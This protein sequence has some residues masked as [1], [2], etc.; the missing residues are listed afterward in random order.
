VAVPSPA[1]FAFSAVVALVLALRSDG[2][3]RRAVFAVA[4]L[5]FLATFC[6]GDPHKL[7]PFAALLLLGYVSLWFVSERRRS[8][9][10]VACVAALLA[11]FFVV[12]R[13][14]FVPSALLLPEGYV[15]VGVSYVFFRLVHLVVDRAQ[16]ALEERVGPVA[17]V[18]YAL[19]FTALVSGPIQLYQ[20]YR[21]TEFVAPA[22]L[23]VTVAGSAFARIVLGCFKVIM[24][25][26]AFAWLQSAAAAGALDAGPRWARTLDLAAAIALFAPYIYV[27]FSGY[28]DIVI[29]T[30]RFLR[31]ELPENF[32]APFA[33]RG[34][35]DFWTRWHMTLSNW[36]KRYVYAPLLLALMRRT[37]SPAAE[38]WLAVGTYFVTF[39]LV[40][41]WHGRTTEFAMFGV[42]Q[43]LGVSA[44]KVYQIVM[45]RRLGRARYRRLC[46]D[47]RYAA[48]SRAA[49]FTWFSVSLLWFW[50]TWSG[51]AGFE[52]AAG[53]AGV[54]FAVVAVFVAAAIVLGIFVPEG[55]AGRLVAGPVRESLRS[56]YAAAAWCAV[57]FVLT[58][59]A[60][61]ISSAPAPH[62]VYKA[63]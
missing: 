27:N 41:L 51:I 26:P 8:R 56:P 7:L 21:K 44:N 36:L 61:V 25:S 52:R 32:A 29:G 12:K 4:N 5:A 63:F 19:S 49:T 22:P 47:P 3:W 9:L 39:F 62:L 13:Y 40:G 58:L 59:S 55:F 46:D 48:L 23:D 17:F 16:G 57:L 45:T 33:A 24:L 35:I 1:F 30:A 50:S 18:S 43:G 42:L 2:G 60:A 20:D 31:L 37:D 15:A 34:F 54:A 38:P 11:A 6:E 28:T 53:A 14:A 10:L